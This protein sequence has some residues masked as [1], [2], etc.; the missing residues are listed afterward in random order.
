[1]ASP[2][3]VAGPED[4]AVPMREFQPTGILRSIPQPAAICIMSQIGHRVFWCLA[5]EMIIVKKLRKEEEEE[6][7][8]KKRLPP[9][10]RIV[11]LLGTAY[12][13]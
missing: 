3:A 11:C 12:V 9:L 1:M 2:V 7:N 5:D 8:Q 13:F 4:P 6:A 10:A